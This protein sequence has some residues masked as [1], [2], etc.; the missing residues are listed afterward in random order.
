MSAPLYIK[1][2]GPCS[3]KKNQRSFESPVGSKKRK[4]QGREG[5][6]EETNQLR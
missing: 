2:S 4:K 5:R 3:K 6:N 1:T